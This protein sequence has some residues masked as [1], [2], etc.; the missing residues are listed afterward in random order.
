MKLSD[1]LIE[2]ILFLEDMPAVGNCSPL[3]IGQD[4]RKILEA[5]L[6]DAEDRTNWWEQ[7]LGLIDKVGLQNY[8]QSQ[9]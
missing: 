2:R 5:M 3:K 4:V 7:Q 6:A 9:M 8:M 1:S